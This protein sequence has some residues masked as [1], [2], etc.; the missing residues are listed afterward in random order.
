MS[1]NKITKLVL[2]FAIVLALT[3]S[4]SVATNYYHDTNPNYTSATKAFG[5]T[6]DTPYEYPPYGLWV[7]A[8]N[9]QLNDSHPKWMYI[10]HRFWTIDYQGVICKYN[11]VAYCS[12]PASYC[13]G[14]GA[15]VYAYTPK[16]DYTLA[17]ITTQHWY[18]FTYTSPYQDP[19]YTA[20][21][22]GGS[23]FA[24][25]YWYNGEDQSNVQ[26]VNGYVMDEG[27]MISSW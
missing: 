23:M 1:N 26:C 2:L 8:Y 12:N 4:P 14:P 19:F 18:D 11:A 7:K 27:T 25:E 5:H 9:F 15:D 6:D 21:W 10:S 20:L 16:G 3:A 17:W 22:D 13:S 24:S